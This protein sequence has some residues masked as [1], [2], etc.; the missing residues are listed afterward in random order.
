M[1][2]TELPTRLGFATT[3]TLKAD[4]TAVGRIVSDRA[5]DLEAAV[6][7][8]ARLVNEPGA[9][10][11]TLGYRAAPIHPTPIDRAALASIR[12]ERLR[13][14]QRR[15]GTLQTLVADLIGR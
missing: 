15:L 2:R 14:I 11:P 4:M 13:D 7:H 5:A 10:E 8:Q 12:D 6:L 1:S 3:E 9:Q